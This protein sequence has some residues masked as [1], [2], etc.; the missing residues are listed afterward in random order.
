MNKS[1]IW[2]I[3]LTTYLVVYIALSQLGGSST[4]ALMFLIAP[5][6]VIWTVYVVLTDKKDYP[7]LP[8]DQEWA[9]R[10]RPDYK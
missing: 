9:Y 2:I 10:D 7:E 5:F 6:L 3:I 1:V 4:I 8:E